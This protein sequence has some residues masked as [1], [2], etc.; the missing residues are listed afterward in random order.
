MSKAGDYRIM[1]RSRCLLVIC[2]TLLAGCFWTS[3]AHAQAG[4][5]LATCA[6][7]WTPFG[8]QFTGPIV[9]CVQ[10]S[11]KSAVAGAMTGMSNYF[12]STTAALFIL[13][14]VMHGAQ[15]LSGFRGQNARG[16][17]FDTMD[18][19]TADALGGYSPWLMIDNILG[20]LMGFAPGVALTQGLVWLGVG[21]VSGTANFGAASAIIVFF[22]ELI[23]FFIEIM[24]VYL[25]AYIVV[26]F[27][28]ILSPMFVPMI[29]FQVSERYF[30]KWLD[31]ILGAMLVPV[32]VFGLLS[33]A[34]QLYIPLIQKIFKIL[35]PLYNLTIPTDPANPPDFSHFFKIDQPLFAF[36]LGT[37]PNLTNHERKKLNEKP[38]NLNN[39]PAAHTIINPFNGAGG[40][41]MN[42]IN[43]PGVNF[44]IHG[45]VIAQQL[46]L[47][48][49]AVWVYTALLKQLME[50]MPGVAQEIAGVSN[51][52]L[53]R[54]PKLKD[55]VNELKS[56]VGESLGTFGGG[57]AGGRLGAALG[58]E[59][60]RAQ[61]AAAIGG[62]I[63]GNVLARK[64]IK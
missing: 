23:L 15:M 2:F 63:I 11:V 9:Q 6:A 16:L 37:D 45:K 17:V 8:N 58:G 28:L 56:D 1:K 41:D 24:Y 50:Q 49:I 19:I 36:N 12:R 61:G 40:F 29:I 38:G 43:A 53:L 26:A 5:D 20:T 54:A 57:L 60:S 27:L 30:R 3:Q 25:T 14:V 39:A 44:G 34:L 4:V 52:I 10:S 59:S 64:L 35:L 55:K 46:M 13:A 62:G 33:V 21:L 51:S 32:F 42:A 48:L 47:A 7:G 18:E 22:I 31:N